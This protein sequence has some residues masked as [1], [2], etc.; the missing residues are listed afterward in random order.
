MCPNCSKRRKLLSHPVP[1][2]LMVSAGLLVWLSA[3]FGVG[4]MLLH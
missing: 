1:F 4:A 3:L 2:T